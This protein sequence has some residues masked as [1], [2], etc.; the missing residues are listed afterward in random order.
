M[1]PPLTLEERELMQSIG[2]TAGYL[3]VCANRLRASRPDLFGPS[4]ATHISESGSIADLKVTYCTLLLTGVLP[5]EDSQGV[6]CKQCG[7]LD[8]TKNHAEFT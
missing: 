8:C 1:N 3:T 7:A 5:P 6:G 4:P 2:G